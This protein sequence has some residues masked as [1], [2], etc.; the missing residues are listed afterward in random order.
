M[1]LLASSL[2]P[3]AFA[4]IPVQDDWEPSWEHWRDYLVPLV[5]R[6]TWLEVEW[7]S[8][9]WDAVVEAHEVRKPILL[10]AMNGHPLGC[11]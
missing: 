11:T 1:L 3:L 9:F 7:H 4:A 5:E 8:V 10:W 2:A 6:E